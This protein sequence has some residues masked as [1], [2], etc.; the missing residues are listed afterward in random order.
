M[1]SSYCNNR[2]WQSNKKFATFANVMAKLLRLAMVADNLTN[3]F[4]IFV[5]VLAIILSLAIIA[6]N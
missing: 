4:A 5:N 2:C 1:S 3:D 6:T